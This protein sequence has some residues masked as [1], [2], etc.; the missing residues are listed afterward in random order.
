MADAGAPDFRPD[1]G[2][3]SG[4][5]NQHGNPPM[6][7]LP[8]LLLPLL[9]ITSSPVLAQTAILP[10]HPPVMDEVVLQLTAEDWVETQTALVTVTA[11]AAEAATEAGQARSDLLAA[12]DRLASDA[13]W[14][15]VRFDRYT[16]STGLERWQASAEARLSEGS[17]TGLADRAKEASRP[18]LQLRVD[19]IEYTP[20]LAEAEAVRARLRADIYRRAEDEIAALNQAFEG[21]NFRIG[22]VHFSEGGRPG[23][24]PYPMAMMAR[25]AEAAAQSDAGQAAVSVK[26]KL[27]LSARVVLSALAPQP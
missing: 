15:I 1:R 19:S 4:Q 22:T 16:D 3:H 10:Q 2:G 26:D 21:R 11:E 27:I 13:E 12:I 8:A 25:S 9:L 20:T 6:R 14:R 7:R 23:P 18:G 5:A 24:E 17:L